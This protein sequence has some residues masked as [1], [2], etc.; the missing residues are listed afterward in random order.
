MTQLPPDDD[1]PITDDDAPDAPP[2]PRRRRKPKVVPIRATV[3]L[4]PNQN[5]RLSLRHNASNQ[6]TKDPGN[7]TLILTHDERFAGCLALNEFTHTIQWAKEPPPLEGMK[8]PRGPYADHHTTYVQHW[9][10]TAWGQTFAEGPTFA[11]V[12]S[13][14]HANAYHPVRDYL[15][16]LVWDGKQRLPSWL[17]TYFGAKPSVYLTQ[18]GTAW[19]ISAVAR[20]LRP[21]CKADYMLVLEGKQGARKSSALALLFGDEWFTD[22]Q[23]PL[24]SDE[25][26]KKLQGKWCVEFAE[27]D[28]FRGKASSQIKMFLSSTKDTFRPSY[29][30]VDQ[31]FPRTCVFVG[32]TNE[33]EYLIDRTGN[34][35]FWPAQV[36]QIDRPAIQNDRNQLWAEA[37]VRYDSNEPW[38]LEVEDLAREEQR[39]REVRE[40]WF[41]VV[42]NWLEHP[43]IYDPN[44]QSKRLLLNHDGFTQADIFEGALKMRPSDMEPRQQQRIGYI[45]H[46]LGY[47]RRRPRDGNSR[48]YRYFPD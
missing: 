24:G 48:Q 7:A 17:A 22:S 8:S 46:K 38:W 16:S 23:I 40:P 33:R 41:E 11:A 21:G 28:A 43:V 44:T 15:R 5:W 29:G 42:Q 1:F 14:A 20:A 4:P 34:R 2:K 35:R 27:L 10:A 47:I 19:M 32:T 25:A 45:M 12:L 36:G 31:D 26:Y 6:I 37:V 3:E 13:A 18:V 39:Q 9:L 30:R